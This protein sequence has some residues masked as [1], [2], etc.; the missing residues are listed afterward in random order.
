MHN[1]DEAATCT[2]TEPIQLPNGNTEP[3]FICTCPTG[4][5]GDGTVCSQID[6][7]T[8]N[9]CNRLRGACG[10]SLFVNSVNYETDLISCLEGFTEDEIQFN[11]RSFAA[12]R[13]KFYK[14]IDGDT[15]IYYDQS[16]GIWRIGGGSEATVTV[17]CTTV[18]IC[19]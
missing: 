6:C 7:P 11:G 1:C 15:F 18:P 8:T 9:N 16:Y 10:G 3:G 13:R 2:D 17:D 19:Q 5:S 12:T 14:E 4:W